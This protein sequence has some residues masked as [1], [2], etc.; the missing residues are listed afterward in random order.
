M[1]PV[2]VAIVGGGP[3]GLSAALAAAEAGARVALID[4]GER[5]GGQF[6]RQPARPPNGQ[7]SS[8]LREH[9]LRGRALLEQLARSHVEVV[10]GTAV[11]NLA[12]RR[13]QLYG[14]G[15]RRDLQANRIVL[16][17]GATERSAAFPGWTLPG[18]MTVGA[19][20]SLL[21]AQGLVPGGRVVV[22]GSGPLLLAV[23]RQLLDH[24]AR[25][26]AVVEATPLKQWLR[27]GLHVGRSASR[28]WEGMDHLQRLTRAGVELHY[29][30]AVT[31]ALGQQQLEG[32]EVSAVDAAWRPHPGTARRLA[33]DA[34]CVSFGLLPATELSRLAGCEHRFDAT[35]GT[36][37]V[38]TNADL[39]TSVTGLYAAGEIRGV[40]GAEA[41]LAEG[42]LAGL[43]AA[44]SL[45]LRL[46]QPAGALA[47]ARAEQA[48]CRAA[49]EAV[50]RLFAVQPGLAD[51]AE[52]D[53]PVCRCEGVTAGELRRA[54]REGALHLNGLKA[55]NRC[56]MGPCQGRT[57]GPIAA[58]I[59][60]AEAGISLEAAGCFTARPP[61]KP[62]PLAVVAGVGAP[63]ASG[64]AMEDHAGY[65]RAVAGRR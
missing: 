16:A 28:L 7:L 15:G 44:E 36:W 53:T 23:A 38:R 34:L 63:E 6:Y 57:C 17:T 52:D 46:S 54:A 47:E 41:A 29:G 22:A 12:P 4:E 25:V 1:P 5:L 11:W 2:D 43:A 33:A 55:W 27:N 48:R 30:M 3:A 42:R 58:Q 51:L 37:V 64:A 39:E 62:V 56:G 65:G 18:V 21:K 60:A 9:F 19:A 26:R 61:I 20:Q 35:L 10:A 40:G 14:P 50:L 45:G 49:A 13:L 59:I 32:V 24:G 8:A 31:R